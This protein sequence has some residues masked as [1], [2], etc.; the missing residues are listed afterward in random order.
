[1]GAWILMLF[2]NLL[3]P[4]VLMGFGSV[5]RNNAPGQ[6]N[7]L[8]GYRTSMSM[9]NQDTWEFANRLWGRLA[10]KW[11]IWM[12]IGSAAALLAVL[13]ASENVVYIVGSVVC[14]VQVLLILAT[15]PIVEQALKKE[16]NSDGSRRNT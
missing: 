16:F 8:F 5:L 13:F 14:C 2:S 9:K 10:W 1:M 12:L 3:I 4:T 15:I 7:A 6:I 11:G